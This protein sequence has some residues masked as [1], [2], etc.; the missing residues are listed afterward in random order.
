MSA[1]NLQLKK[2]IFFSDGLALTGT[3]H[4]PR[5]EK[6]PVVIGLHGLYSSQ[7]SPKQI[8]LAGACNKL[9]LAYL[10][11][12]H[13]GCGRSQGEFEKVTSLAARCRDLKSAIETVKGWPDTSGQIGLFGSSMGGTVS[14][15]VAADL[16]L[17]TIVTFAA[18][19]RTRIPYMRDQSQAEPKAAAIYLDPDKSEFDI[20][21]CIPRIAN[22]LVIHGDG[23]QT[24]PVSHAKEIYSLAAEP[25]KL[26]IQHQG[27]HRMSNEQH[28]NDFIRA[29]SSWLK[30][31]LAGE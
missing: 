8:A 5:S 2:I 31:G 30:S 18:P 7:E 15:S 6:P 4:L 28:Q 3:L 25:K 21:A 14:L 26:I 22:I 19:L 1:E 13:R 29:A 16:N 20:C 9:G 10:R 23:D 24:V 11:F 12:D 27:D 17:D